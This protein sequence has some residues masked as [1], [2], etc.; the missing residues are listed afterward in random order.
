MR[1]WAIQEPKF[2][3]EDAEARLAAGFCVKCSQHLLNA[4]ALYIELIIA[5]HGRQ[6]TDG[7]EVMALWLHTTV[8]RKFIGQKQAHFAFTEFDPARRKRFNQ[9]CNFINGINQ[10]HRGRTTPLSS[11]ASLKWCDRA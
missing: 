6:S 3:A 4:S 2:D 10:I 1:L 11:R 7:V 5:L 9:P 8:M